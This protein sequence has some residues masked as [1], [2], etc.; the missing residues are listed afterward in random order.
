M[1]SIFGQ[2]ISF[3]KHR[4]IMGNM[5]QFNNNEMDFTVEHLSQLEAKY[6]NPLANRKYQD[7]NADLIEYSQLYE[8]LQNM[9][10]LTQNGT[11]QL[12]LKISLQGL[13][14]AINAFHLN[15][16][17][18]RSNMNLLRTQNRLVK[19]DQNSVY[20]TTESVLTAS[21]TYT[22]APL[23]SYYILLFGIPTDGFEPDKIQKILEILNQYGIHP[24]Q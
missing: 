1:K 8:N 24:Y 16:E 6:M 12:L 18:V 7:I 20:D 15:S 22:L 5:K 13:T 14:G 10:L 21:K 17:N 19:T 3:D 23:Y 11:M 2:Q 4:P 9:C